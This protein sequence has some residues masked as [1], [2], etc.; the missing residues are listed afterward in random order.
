MKN[1]FI[2][3]LFIVL[4]NQAYAQCIPNQAYANS[5]PGLHP[6]Y[7]DTASTGQPYAAQLNIKTITDTAWLFNTLLVDLKVKATRILSV[8]GL[9]NGFIVNP[10]YNNINGYW[11]NGGTDPNW[12]PILGCINF[13]AQAA[14]VQAALNGGPN[15]D[16]V[17]PLTIYV[18]IQAKG[19]PV[20]ST[21]AWLS[22]LGTPPYGNAMRKHHTHLL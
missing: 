7:L 16:G 12:T 8:T 11:L 21:Y 2:A 19:N 6:A 17:Y 10:N 14:D 20:P 18:D 13:S 3:V 1:L 15:N 22:S 4:G 5:A 9:P